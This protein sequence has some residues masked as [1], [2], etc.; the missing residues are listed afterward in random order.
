MIKGFKDFLLRGNVVDLA[1]A[2][3]IGTAFTA[4]VTSF[5]DSFLRAADRPDR[6]RRRERRR[7]SRSTASTFT[8]GAFI[9][10][11]ITLRA[12]RGGRL[13]RR[14]AADEGD[15]G[16]AQA[17]RGGRARRSRPRSSCW[18]RSA[19]CSARSRA[20]V[21]GATRPGPAR[22]PCPGSSELSRCPSAAAG[23]P[24]SGGRR[25]PGRRG[26]S[27]QPTSLSSG[28]RAGGAGA[29]AR[30]RLGRR[31]PAGRGPRAPRRPAG[32]RAATPGTAS[33]LPAGPGADDDEVRGRHRGSTSTGQSAGRPT[34][35]MP[36]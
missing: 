17:R 29:G 18:S 4:L 19:T 13:L 23:P 34:G 36:P 8:W 6:R 16:A 26:R 1:V 12:H 22:R 2:V 25:R 32:R 5:T 31:A 24:G 10:A 15:H 33:L 14:R 20:R 35:V 3:V 27:P 9:N 21:P 7:R 28:A 11:V 30:R